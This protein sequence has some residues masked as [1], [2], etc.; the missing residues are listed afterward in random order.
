VFTFCFIV[1]R[2]SRRRHCHTLLPMR[3]HLKPTSKFHAVQVGYM[4]RVCLSN[5]SLRDDTR[6]V[7][8]ARMQ[9]E[10]TTS[11]TQHLAKRFGRMERLLCQLRKQAPAEPNHHHDT[12]FRREHSHRCRSLLETGC[13]HSDISSQ[14]AAAR[15][16]A[17]PTC[18][19]APCCQGYRAR[20]TP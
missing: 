14:G 15:G 18:C 5:H 4:I 9:F 16:N 20:R 2:A 1:D 12:G 17:D 19:N 3:Q 7:R 11:S 6:R 13:I 8:T 10:V